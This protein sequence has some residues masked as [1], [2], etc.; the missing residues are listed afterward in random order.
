MAAAAIL[1]IENRPYMWK[2]STD[3]RE[4]WH[5]DAHWATE[6]DRKLK[7]PTFKN[8]RLRTHAILKIENRPY[9]RKD[10]TDLREIW[11]DDALET[12]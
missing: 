11:Y 9:L 5:D 2:G 6:P 12:H 3:L 8:P 1:K 7:F 4:I 10:L